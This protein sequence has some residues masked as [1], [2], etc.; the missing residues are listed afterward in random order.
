MIDWDTTFI[1]LGYTPE[2][3]LIIKRPKVVCL[4]DKC[5]KSAV[6]TIRVKSKVVGDQM[7]WICP[8]CVGLSRSADISKQM[9]SQ[10]TDQQYRD[11]Q[12]TIKNNVI[13]KHN[14]AESIKKK[15]NTPEYRSR[16]ET[17]IN[18]T[19]FIARSKQ[20]YGDKFD[21]S[22]TIF[23]NWTSHIIVTCTSCGSSLHK[24]P[25]KH[26][27]HGFCD[28]CGGS[29]EQS[30]I[31]DFITSLTQC[32]VNDR[33]IISPLELDIFIPS[34]KL[35]IEY[36]GAYWHSYAQL[37]TS[38]ERLRH[39]H[40]ALICN[41]AGIRLLQFFDFEW[42]FKKD[43]VKSMITHSLQMSNQ[44]NA[45][46]LIV[47]QLSQSD[48]RIFF[49]N[50]HIYGDRSAKITLAL[51][52]NGAPLIAASFSKYKDGYELIRMATAIGQSVRGGA[53]RL[54]TNFKK[55]HNVPIYTFADMRYSTGNVYNQIGFKYLK[56]T[57]P[58]Y[59]YIKNETVLSRQKC[60]KNKLHKLLQDF[61]ESLSESSNMF[62]NGFRRIWDAGHIQLI[63][64]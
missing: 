22:N 50:N 51:T 36:H 63:L 20:L 58:N 61:D 54:L 15:W 37:E 23:T 8:S 7:A 49:D 24:M 12:T 13:Y 2:T 9:A 1:K 6:I 45:R 38:T 25:Q 57:S 28:Y 34:H 10:W 60:Q 39:Q 18:V 32:T 27:E 16:L 43:I 31:T 48:S 35:A 5:G 47:S 56:T 53:S 4:C 62:N 19:E 33:T 44:H 42:K 29:K 40:K 64:T 17:G 14:M 21:Y 30:E 11:A 3:A 26:I 41:T 55:Q 46:D 59:Y 52:L